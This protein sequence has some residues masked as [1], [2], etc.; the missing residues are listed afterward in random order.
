LRFSGCTAMLH[1]IPFAAT[2]PL[3]VATHAQVADTGLAGGRD[4]V[5]RLG[6]PSSVRAK[7]IEGEFPIVTN[8][9]GSDNPC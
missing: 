8:S 1:K 3:A 6:S 7:R 4:L 9:R 2:L 5:A